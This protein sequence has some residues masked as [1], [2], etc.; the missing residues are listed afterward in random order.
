VWA[1]LHF[2]INTF[3]FQRQNRY[4]TVARE[5]PFPLAPEPSKTLPP[6]PRLEQLDRLKGVE[7]SNAYERQLSKEE[8]LASYGPTEEKGF[9]HI[10]IEQAMHYLAGKLPAR[11]EQA[12]D[13]RAS[14]LLDAGGPNSGRMFRTEL[15]RKAQ[16]STR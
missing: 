13:Q 10:P 9:V 3:F 16:W 6:E 4:E 14:G 11:P 15:K 12:D 1:V 5:S 8:V 2:F 7:S